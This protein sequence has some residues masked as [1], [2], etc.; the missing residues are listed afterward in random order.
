MTNTG[1]KDKTRAETIIGQIS[2]RN[3][4]GIKCAL[5]RVIGWEMPEKKFLVSILRLLQPRLVVPCLY[6]RANSASS[7]HTLYLL[8]VNT[9]TTKQ[10]M[11][12]LLKFFPTLFFASFVAAQLTITKPSST[13]WWGK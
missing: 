5:G 7:N 3:Q 9:T 10:K 11:M 13:L 4:S 2:I 12:N 1:V 8:L 6:P